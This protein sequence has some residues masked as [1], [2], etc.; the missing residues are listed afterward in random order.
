MEANLLVYL[1]Y[2]V[3]SG[4]RLGHGTES[5]FAPLKAR[6]LGPMAACESLPND[7]LGEA[8]C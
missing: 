3:R 5:P 6:N 2:E 4:L 8:A 7:L 1:I